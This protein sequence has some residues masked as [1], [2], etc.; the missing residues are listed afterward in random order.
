MKSKFLQKKRAQYVSILDASARA[1]FF[2][3]RNC[4]HRR[5]EDTQAII[6]RYE[7]EIATL[8]QERFV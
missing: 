4:Q 2:R 6:E 7:R 5:C 3:C 8:K 1:V